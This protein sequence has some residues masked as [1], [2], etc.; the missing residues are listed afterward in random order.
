M[1]R[2]SRVLPWEVCRPA[3]GNGCATGAV[4]RRDGAAEGSRGRSSRTKRRRAERVDGGRTAFPTALSRYLARGPKP[5]VAGGTRKVGLG[6]HRAA[7][8]EDLKPSATR[9]AV[10][11]TVRTVVW[12]GDA[13]RRPPTPDLP[14]AVRKPPCTFRS[15]IILT[16]RC[17]RSEPRSVHQDR[18][19]ILKQT[20][21]G[22]LRG[23]LRVR[24][25]GP[26]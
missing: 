11:G 7:G 9:T 5:E 25:D 19:S 4:R 20:L 2:K 16:L 18:T 22:P 17:E 24:V 10:Y 6:A 3:P 14:E 15:L 8:I 13:E 23:H 12:E 26:T 21:R 1:A